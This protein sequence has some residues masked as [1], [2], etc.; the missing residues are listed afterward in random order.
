MNTVYFMSSNTLLTLAGFISSGIG[1]LLPLA[2]IAVIATVVR[3]HR[4]DV[5][6]LLLGAMSFECLISVVSYVT[7]FALPHVLTVS[8]PSIA[9]RS[10]YTE[11]YALSN[12]IFSVGHAAARILLLWGIVRLAQP[13]NR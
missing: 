9:G 6:P 11:A 12:V 4:P 3:R 5:T 2:F 13:P 10:S 8:A 1:V 7:M